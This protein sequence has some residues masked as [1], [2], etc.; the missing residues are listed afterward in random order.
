MP[1]VERSTIVPLGLDE[2]WEAFFGNQ[3]QNWLQLSDSVDDIRDFRWRKDGTPEYVMINRMG[4]F[5]PSHQSDYLVYEPPHRAEDD[6]LDS[7]LGGRWTTLHEQVEGG[8]RVTHRW[9]VEPKGL[10]KVLFPLMRRGF[11]RAF[12]SDLD[13]MAQ[14][15]RHRTTQR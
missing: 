10:M 11:E 12:Q 14:R 4:P 9:D 8:T 5:R 6:T 7:M 1:I 2:A 15:I 13:T 3:M